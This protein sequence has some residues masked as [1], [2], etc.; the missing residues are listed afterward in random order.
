MFEE[1]NITL[2]FSEIPTCAE[3]LEELIPDDA[4]CIAVK[5]NLVDY[6]PSDNNENWL[7]PQLNS[8]RR[9][10]KDCGVEIIGSTAGIH[11][12]GRRQIPHIHYHFI[13]NHYNEPSNA[14]QHRRRWLGKNGNEEEN[15]TDISIKYSSL[16]RNKPKYQFLSYPLKEGKRLRQSHYYTLNGIRMTNEM[17]NFLLSVG[18]TIY[19]TQVALRIRQDKCVERK[20]LALQELYEICQNQNFSSFRNMMEWLDDNYIVSLDLSEY[21]DPKNYKVNCQKIAIKLGLLKYSSL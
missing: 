6:D 7:P 4:T 8:V 5:I 3:Q 15:L 10:L 19:D 13:C 14:S 20:Q 1:E 18:R 17:F 12:E 2:T 16:E 21:P 9:Y 11:T